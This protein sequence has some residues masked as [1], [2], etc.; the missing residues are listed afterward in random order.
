MT[1]LDLLRNH[2]SSLVGK[3]VEY[4]FGGSNPLVLTVTGCK[5]TPW[6]WTDEE[7][8]EH[9]SYTYAISEDGW[10]WYTVDSVNTTIISE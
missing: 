2:L 7:G 9:T 6:N 5:K 10:S 3:T 1:V 8:V 4:E